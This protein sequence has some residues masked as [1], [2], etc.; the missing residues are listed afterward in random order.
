MTPLLVLIL[1]LTGIGII[2]TLY[3]SYHSLT[4]TPV[5]CL[6]FPPEWCEKVQ[7]SK[8]SRT[9]GVPN[10]MAGLTIYSAIFILTLLYSAGMVSFTP[11]AVLVIIGLIF[12][13]YFTFIQAFVLKAFCTW[14]VVSAID[15]I[16][17]FV[18]LLL[19]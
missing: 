11:I 10:S 8:Y 19:R 13:M 1:V 5:R 9:L 4:K 18:I 6:F 16:L 7:Y 15:F 2:N 14:C 12:S 3:L 17:L